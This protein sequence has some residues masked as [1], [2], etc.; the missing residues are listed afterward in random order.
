M[1][2]AGEI[3]PEFGSTGERL[4]RCADDLGAALIE[5]AW[6]VALVTIPVY[7][8]VYSSRSFEPD[9]VALL[10]VLAGM[11]AAAWLARVL[12]GGALWPP[13]SAARGRYRAGS[14]LVA[15]AAAFLLASALAT[16]L[17]LSPTRS[18][19]GSFFRQQ[20]LETLL[21]YVTIALAVVAH[22]RRAEQ[23]RRA[24][25]AIMVGSIPVCA[26]AIVQRVGLDAIVPPDDIHR[27]SSSLGN[28]IFLGSYLAMVFL[29]TLSRL[30]AARRNG[31][32]AADGGGRRFAYGAMCGLQLTAMVLSQSRGPLIGLGAGL[33]VM[34][35]AWSLRVRAARL[36]ATAAGTRRPRLL[37]LV[38]AAGAGALVVLGL[39]AASGPQL[40]RLRALPTVGRIAT[41]FD[42]AAPTARVR[43][44]IWRGVVELETSAPPLRG[45]D[46]V[47][48][49]LGDV[50]FLVGYGPDCFDLA[51][52][53]VFPARL[54]VV[55][56]RQSIP[57][58]AHCEVFDLLVTTGVIGLGAW[59]ALIAVALAVAG[60]LA[61]DGTAAGSHESLEPRSGRW[62]VPR[63]RR[64]SGSSSA[65]PSWQVCW[66][67]SAWSPGRV[68]R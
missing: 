67:P 22:M 63:R 16:V 53:R 35:L 3:A 21:C 42:P 37:L 62:G 13:I 28:P 4:R 61:V 7:F 32:E 1:A 11:A 24:A 55:E 19:H 58:R 47:R 26:Y 39:L 12:A 65:T 10:M 59:L 17:S 45:P 30:L 57:D 27:V 14:V 64:H 52:N 20:G 15:A 50:R 44:L 31:P 60:E 25:T 33:L 43:L 49:R 48:D 8:N 38:V 40:G 41:A 68:P 6:L 2:G 34:S 23:W 18:W 54:G 5:A 29:V 46:G 9:K 36:L 56:T 66:R 51:F